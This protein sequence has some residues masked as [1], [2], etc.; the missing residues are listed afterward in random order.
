[1]SYESTKLIKDILVSKNLKEG[2]DKDVK[3]RKSGEKEYSHGRC[4]G[5]TLISIKETM[6]SAEMEHDCINEIHET[7]ESFITPVTLLE[8]CDPLTTNTRPSG[9]NVSNIASHKRCTT[10]VKVLIMLALIVIQI[11]RAH[12]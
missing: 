9:F 11:G 10:I 8:I 3:A 4:T 7:S 2:L 6:T 12:V 5:T 1:M